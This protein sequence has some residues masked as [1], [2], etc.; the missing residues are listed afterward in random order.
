MV[1]HSN[2]QKK[3]N[4]IPVEVIEEAC[5]IQGRSERDMRSTFDLGK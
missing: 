5:D 2:K 4:H 3:M 1:I